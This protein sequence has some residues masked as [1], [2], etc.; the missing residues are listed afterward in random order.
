MSRN[1][2]ARFARAFLFI[3]QLCRSGQCRLDRY[4]VVVRQRFGLGLRIKV[5]L[6]QPLDRKRPPKPPTLRLN[7][8]LP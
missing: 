4:L 8:P 1:L 5:G 7:K 3:E 6:A 2:N